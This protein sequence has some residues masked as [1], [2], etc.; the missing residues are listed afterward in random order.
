MLIVNSDILFCVEGVQNVKFIAIF[1]LP[2]FRVFSVQAIGLS[3]P[4]ARK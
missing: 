1:R 2:I 4:Q 3:I